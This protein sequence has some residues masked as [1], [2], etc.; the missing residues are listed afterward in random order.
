MHGIYAHVIGLQI[1]FPHLDQGVELLVTTDG[2]LQVTWCDTL[3]LFDR[4][5]T[6]N[7]LSPNMKLQHTMCTDAALQQT[8]HHQIWYRGQE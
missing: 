4:N 8:G 7:Q 2:E 6:G 5:R 1:V 3:H